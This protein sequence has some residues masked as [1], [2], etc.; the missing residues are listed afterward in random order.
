MYLPTYKAALNSRKAPK[1]ILMDY[2]DYTY[3]EVMGKKSQSIHLY[4]Y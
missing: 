2:L 4:F 1:K 3:S